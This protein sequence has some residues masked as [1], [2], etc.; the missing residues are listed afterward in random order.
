M[1]TLRRPGANL[2][3]PNQLATLLL[4]GMVSLAYLYELARGAASRHAFV[5]T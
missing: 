3:Q 2:G 1:Q 5:C 4:M